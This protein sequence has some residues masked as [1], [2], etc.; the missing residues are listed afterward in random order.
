MQPA[1]AHLSLGAAQF[2]A[3]PMGALFWPDQHL[4]IVADLHLEK[5]S[6][7]AARRIF[8]PPY[9]TRATLMALA[10][11]IA[12]YA[13]RRVLALGDSFHDGDAGDRLLPR[14]RAALAALQSRRDWIWVAGNH[15]PVLPSDLGGD[16]CQE[17]TI[18]GITF[19]HAADP[20]CKDYEIA[21]HLHPVARVAGSAGSVRRRCFV[22]DNR[23]CILPALGAY[24]GGLNLLGRGLRRAV[25]ARRMFCACL[26]PRSRL[27]YR[28]APLPAGLMP[29]YFISLAR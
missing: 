29:L 7:Y 28:A 22:A 10:T 2:V 8:L 19:R 17:M 11:L 6:A 3:D 15:D 27:S 12:R 16:R 13:P 18:G 5:G 21:G 4:L 20:E 9:D 14:D 26:G 24:A 25:S 1:S 23:R